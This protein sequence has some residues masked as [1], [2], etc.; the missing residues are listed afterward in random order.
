M[1]LAAAVLGIVVLAARVDAAVGVGDRPP[2]LTLP[3]RDGAPFS[4]GA[5]HGRVVLLDFWASWCLPCTR[6]LP[7]LDALARRLASDGLVVVAIGIDQDPATADRYLADRVPDPAMTMVRDPGGRWLA[8]FGARGMPALYVL[9]REG[10]VRLVEV[11]YDPDR[12]EHVEAEVRKLLTT[13][14]K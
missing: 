12:L 14:R 3:T 8:R 10:V 5:T 9:D 6:A 11:G 1:R 7:R 4:V 13:P 2:H